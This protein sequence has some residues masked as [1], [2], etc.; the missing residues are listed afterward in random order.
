M[1][2]TEFLG[3]LAGAL[4]DVSFGVVGGD[5]TGGGLFPLFSLSTAIFAIPIPGL[6]FTSK[7]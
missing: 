7:T 6:L 5:V 4:F 1:G 3:L 2:A